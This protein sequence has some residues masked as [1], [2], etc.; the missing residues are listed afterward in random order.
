LNLATQ[1]QGEDALGVPIEI[2]L[3]RFLVT[4][5]RPV[6][7]EF[8]KAIFSRLFLGKL[9]L[10]WDRIASKKAQLFWVFSSDGPPAWWCCPIFVQ[11]ARGC[12]PIF[13]ESR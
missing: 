6:D 4:F 3:G 5:F 11:A 8:L 1:W 2:K 10:P 7:C 13:T 9:E 12:L